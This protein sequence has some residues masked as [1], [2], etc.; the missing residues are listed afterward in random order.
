MGPD[1]SPYADGV[2]FLDI[3]FPTD[4]PFKAPKVIF[5]TK[6][7]HC[8]V[9]SNGVIC[10]GPGGFMHNLHMSAA[11]L[12]SRNFI[13]AGMVSVDWGPNKTIVDVLKGI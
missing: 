9:N 6:I 11:G 4:Y 13:I 3:N 7:Y 1:G 5:T 12:S 10:D 2:F 8:N